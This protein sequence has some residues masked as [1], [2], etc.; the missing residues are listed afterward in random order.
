LKALQYLN[1]LTIQTAGTHSPLGFG[2]TKLA[3]LCCMLD[4]KLA[5]LDARMHSKL[6]GF[7]AMITEH[8]CTVCIRSAE[9]HQLPSF[10]Y[11]L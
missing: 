11:P 7:A 1:D 4:V 6:A 2:H 8:L 9:Y 3:K 5:I 10:F